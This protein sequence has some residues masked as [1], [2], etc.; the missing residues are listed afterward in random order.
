RRRQRD[1]DGSRSDDE[2]DTGAA[3]EELV[4]E[5]Y[6]T[7]DRRGDANLRLFKESARPGAPKFKRSRASR[8]RVLGLGSDAAG[9]MLTIDPASRRDEAEIRLVCG[10]G[11]AKE[12]QPRYHAAA[13]WTGQADGIERVMPLVL[14]ETHVQAMTGEDYILLDDTQTQTN[15]K[16]IQTQSKYDDEAKDED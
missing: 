14:A 9:S 7:V 5:R 15:S 12:Q 1:D 8:N 11:G 16:A 2:R 10:I 6:V 13:D 4:C 3:L